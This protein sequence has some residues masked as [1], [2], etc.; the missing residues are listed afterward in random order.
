MK[1]SIIR[2]FQEMKIDISVYIG[3][4]LNILNEILFQ[5]VK[6][7]VGFRLTLQCSLC[8]KIATVQ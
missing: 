4:I 7:N 1:T 3:E 2:K 8:K 5:N 6:N